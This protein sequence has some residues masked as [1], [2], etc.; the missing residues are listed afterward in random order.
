MGAEDF[1][2]LQS[3]LNKN[4]ED[5]SL[6]PT[7]RILKFQRGM[8]HWPFGLET[9]NTHHPSVLARYRAVISLSLYS[10]A[11]GAPPPGRGK[12]QHIPTGGA[13]TQVS[14]WILSPPEYCRY[15]V[16]TIILYNYIISTSTILIWFKTICDTR[17]RRQIVH[18]S[19]C[20]TNKFFIFLFN[21]TAS[22]LKD[23]IGLR[24][25]GD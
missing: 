25:W 15:D 10:I 12:G 11:A 3:L 22:Y 24:P 16:R 18:R 5:W 21:Y 1:S 13:R 17:Q 8:Q 9:N 19:Y 23:I 2:L 6:P 14:C 7:G 20:D 4:D